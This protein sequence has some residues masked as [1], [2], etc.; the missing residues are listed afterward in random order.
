MYSIGRPAA[1][2]A[3]C[4]R[5]GMVPLPAQPVPIFET[6]AWLFF[7]A[8][9]LL[10]LRACRNPTSLLKTLRADLHGGQ[11]LGTGGSASS[12]SKHPFVQ[13]Y[14]R[15]PCRS[16]WWATAWTQTSCL[17]RTGAFRPASCCQVC[18]RKN[19]WAVKAHNRN[20]RQT[21]LRCIRSTSASCCQVC[22]RI[23]PQAVKAKSHNF[24]EAKKKT[25][26]RCVVSA[27]LCSS[28]LVVAIHT[29][30]PYLHCQSP[31]STFGLSDQ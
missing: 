2:I 20:N 16:A 28:K 10:P 11:P 3:V 29:H 31:F 15:T 14:T 17:A 5:W 24:L 30:E 13:L 1:F 4:I 8:L 19:P 7:K 21:L 23:K 26:L 18:Y 22:Y 12:F 9:W 27:R 6:W 25:Y